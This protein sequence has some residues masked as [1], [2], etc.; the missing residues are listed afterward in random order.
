MH[1]AHV[2]SSAHAPAMTLAA[3]CHVASNDSP[4]TE[5]A[6]PLSWLPEILRCW[7]LTGTLDREYCFPHH[8]RLKS[9]AAR[10]RRARRRPP[11]L[12]CPMPALFGWYSSH[13]RE[14]LGENLARSERICN[15]RIATQWLTTVTMK[16]RLAAVCSGATS[17]SASDSVT[18]LDH[19]VKRSWNRTNPAAVL[20]AVRP[21]HSLGD[22]DGSCA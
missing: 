6:W 5:I 13:R 10:R 19:S 15:E 7:L 11:C 16:V 21:G 2:L 1:Y 9:L 14:T 8:R 17:R 3:P 22:D 4:P 12:K 18:A 20:H